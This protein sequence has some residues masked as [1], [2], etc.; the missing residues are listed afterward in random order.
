MIM[1]VTGI[2]CTLL[3][4]L[5]EADIFQSCSNFTVRSLPNP[6]H[7]LD[8]DEDVLEEEER[9]SQQSLGRGIE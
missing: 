7:N 9:L 6:E 8:L 5:I 2:V 3:L 4:A 1:A